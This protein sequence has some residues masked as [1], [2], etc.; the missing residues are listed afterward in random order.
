MYTKIL[1]PIDLAQGS[2]WERALP[3]ACELARPAGAELHVMTVVPDYGMSI[4]GNFF[5][6]GYERE[7]L[8]EA[9]TQLKAFLEDGR[10]PSDIAHV[11]GHVA[12]GSIYEEIIRVADEL[13]CDLIVLASHRPELKDYLLGPNAARVVRH[14]Q[15]SVHVVRG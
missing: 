11:E 13:H 4:V 9:R 1:L 6:K 10:V 7:A 12:H 14:A 8:A 15:Q 3:V 5:P 2:S